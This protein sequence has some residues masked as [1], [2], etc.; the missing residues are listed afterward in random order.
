MNNLLTVENLRESIDKVYEYSLTGLPGLK[1]C[2]SIANEFRE[3]Y[4]TESIDDKK[5]KAIRRFINN[6]L[7]KATTTGFI[8]GLGGL[9]IL[10]ITLPAD[11]VSILYIQMQTIST[12]AVLG[13][14]DPKNEEVKTLA[15][16]CLLNYSIA[17][18]LKQAGIKAGNRFTIKLIE[19]LPQEVIKKINQRAMQRLVTKAGE[20][21]IVNLTKLAPLIGGIVG[22]GIDYATT[23]TIANRA[24]KLFILNQLD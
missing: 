8:T 9:I 17:E 6:Q 5:P 3:K 24:Y 16:A 15:Y 22:G 10:P 13:G 11:L 12:I 7:S 19:K 21:G 23:K 1:S 4:S 14:Y 2:Y 18:A 20:T